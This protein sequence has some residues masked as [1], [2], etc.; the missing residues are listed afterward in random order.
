LQFLRPSFS[1][2]AFSVKIIV[3]MK[4]LFS[5][6]RLKY[7]QDNRK[8][9]GC[10]FCNALDSEDGPENLIVARAE[11]CFLILNRYPYTSG[12]L[13]VLPYKHV[14][15]LDELTPEVRAEMMELSTQATQVLGR[16]YNAQGYNLGANLGAAAGAGIEYHLHLHI[17]PRWN[18]DTN[19]MTAVGQTRVLPQSLAESY[20]QIKT[21]WDSVHP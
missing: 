18:G 6:W 1:T 12:H 15:H 2:S 9:E 20:A 21:A 5:P 8:V 16:V 19:F 4:H 17:V 13:M 3:A 11:Y 10:V 7:I 14:K